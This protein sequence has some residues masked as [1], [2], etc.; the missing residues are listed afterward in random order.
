MIAVMTG[1]PGYG[2]T[3]LFG[4]IEHQ[5]GRD[6][7]F[8]FVPAFEPETPPLDHIRRHVVAALFRK[9][10]DAPST[11][12]LALAR[13]CRPAFANYFAD[14]P[15]TLAARHNSI[16]QRLADSPEAVLEVVRSVKTLAP[17]TKLADS[18]VSVLPSDAGVVRALA[19]GWAPA[20]WSDTAR[21]W[22]RGE[23]LPEADLKAVGLSNDSTDRDGSC[24]KPVPALF[25]H[26]LSR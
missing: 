9:V 5:V 10:G 3:H 11:L 22:L 21:R 4:R 24:S 18:L 7:F 8:V 20:P 17:F 15:P 16:R 23:D 12:E 26:M 1:P 6:V 25:Q 14:L 13:L 2:K 19:L